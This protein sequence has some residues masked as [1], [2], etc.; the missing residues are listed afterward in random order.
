MSLKRQVANGLTLQG[1]YTYSHAIDYTDDDGWTGLTFNYAPIL[2]RNRATASYDRTHNFHLAYVYEFPFGKGKKYAQSGVAAV[3]LGGWQANG[4]IAM[5]SGNPFT[6][7]AD[8][9][10]LN[11]PGN[12]QTADLVGTV[13]KIGSLQEYYDITAF[14]P[15]NTP[16]F[17][18]I[19]R[20]TLRG[21]GVINNDLSLFRDFNITERIKLTFKAEAFNVTNTPHFG[22]PDGGSA[23]GFGNSASVN[24]TTFMVISSSAGT[25]ADQRSIRFGLRVGW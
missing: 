3:V 13:H 5:Y 21:P 1:A 25:L 15:V 16:R 24:D 12:T 4:I 11:A 10:A 22:A 14:A 18:N 2:G 23:N 20:N 17:G 9:T 6:V 8:G 7:T 19:G